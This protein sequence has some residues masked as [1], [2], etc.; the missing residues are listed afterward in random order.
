MSG[1]CPEQKTRLETQ[2]PERFSFYAPRDYND[3]IYLRTD[4]ATLVGKKYQPKRNHVNKF[5]KTY[6]YEYLPITSEL[7]P[8]CLRFEA[9][10]CR[11]HDCNAADGTG[12]ERQAVLDGLNNFDA[13]GLTGGALRVGDDLVAFTF[14]M[15]ISADTFGVHVEKADTRFDGAYAV[16]NYEFANR[17]PEQYIYLNREEDMGVE[18]LRKAKLSYHPTILLE[19]YTATLI[20]N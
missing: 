9:Q 13:L 14:G 18:G 11:M 10:W 6:S 16:I 3:Y 19:K 20:E 5:K 7:I 2:M 8:E 17:V 15:P 4:L 1:I 12:N